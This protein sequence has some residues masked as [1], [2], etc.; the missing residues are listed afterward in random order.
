LIKLVFTDPR[1]DTNKGA[2]PEGVQGPEGIQLQEMMACHQKYLQKWKN[3]AEKGNIRKTIWLIML[4][5]APESGS[6]IVLPCISRKPKKHPSITTEIPFKF[7]GVLWCL[8][9]EL[10]RVWYSE[11]WSWS[12]VGSIKGG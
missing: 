1:T 8:K 4:H 12:T 9:G 7:K 6:R 2:D 11:G 3:G 5:V 10:S